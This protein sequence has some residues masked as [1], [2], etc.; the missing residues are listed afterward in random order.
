MNCTRK[1]C[2]IELITGKIVLQHISWYSFVYSKNYC[3]SI[4]VKRSYF[5]QIQNHKF[6]KERMLTMRTSA[7][8]NSDRT[9]SFYYRVILQGPEMNLS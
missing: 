3:N 9:H 4:K 7:L 5:P 8:A 1:K 6:G 2:C